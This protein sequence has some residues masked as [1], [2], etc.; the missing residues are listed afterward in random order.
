MLDKTT[1]KIRRYREEI[2]LLKSVHY[3]DF[4]SEISKL[5]TKICK[6]ETIV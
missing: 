5:E 6:L 4:K 2:E 1:E 3:I